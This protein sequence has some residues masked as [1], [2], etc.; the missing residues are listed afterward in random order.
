MKKSLLKR[1]IVQKTFKP[2]V[3]VSPVLGEGAPAFEIVAVAKNEGFDLFVVGHR[4]WG[5]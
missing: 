3:A 5:G 2:S 4:V 1:L